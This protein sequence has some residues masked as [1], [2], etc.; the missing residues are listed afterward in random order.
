MSIFWLIFSGLFFLTIYLFILLKGLW[1][2]LVNLG[3][4]G[5]EFGSAFNR[6]ASPHLKGYV[7]AKSVYEAPE[8]VAQARGQHKMIKDIRKNNRDRRMEKAV[9]RWDNQTLADYERFSP[10][11]REKIKRQRRL[12]KNGQ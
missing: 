1:R 6:Y 9:S 3:K 7:S 4:A 12:A 10:E 2:S 11:N 8:R 5:S